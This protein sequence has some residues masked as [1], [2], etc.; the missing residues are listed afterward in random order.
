MDKPDKRKCDFS[1]YATRYN[2]P[3]SDGRTIRNKAFDWQDGEIV[4]LVWSHDHKTLGNVLGH[5]LLEKRDDGMFSR[6][7]AIGSTE[8]HLSFFVLLQAW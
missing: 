7:C 8:S 3:C 2:V 4:P 1:G 5:A 6:V